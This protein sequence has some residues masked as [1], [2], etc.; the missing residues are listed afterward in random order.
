MD[1]RR[2]IERRRGDLERAQAFEGG[3]TTVVGEVECIGLGEIT[4]EVRFP[5][6]FTKLP[7]IDG[8]GSVDPN[9]PI[10]P[11]MF[12]EWKVG[13]RQ[14]E[15]IEVPEA[16]DGVWYV[17]ATLIVIVEGGTDPMFKSTAWWSASGPA[18]SNPT[19]SGL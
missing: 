13:V 18:L 12:P 16:P 9:Q 2:G 3:E 15:T 4:I 17:G 1:I 14:W 6:A 7:V 19:V 11:G 8:S 10:V 5:V